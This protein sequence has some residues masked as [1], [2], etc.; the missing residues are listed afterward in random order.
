[1]LRRII[2]TMAFIA[3]GASA[4]AQSPFEQIHGDVLRKLEASRMR[5]VAGPW[6]KLAPPPTANQLL[7]DVQHYT[8]S[9]AINPTTHAVEGTVQAT[10]KSL[11]SGLSTIDLDADPVLTIISARIAGGAAL[12]FTR[13]SGVVTINLPAPL[14]GADLVTIEVSYT[15]DPTMAAEPGLFFRLVGTTQ[16]IYSLSE[17]W[18]ARAWWP[19]KDQPDDKAAFD[20]YLAVPEGLQAVSNG[21]F[22]GSAL[23]T[24]WGAWYRSYHWREDY[25]MSA[26]LASV[27]AT[28]YTELR[29]NFVY[30]PGDTMP[31]T[32]YVYPSLVSKALTDLSITAP[33]LSFF[34]SLFGLYP[35]VN[36]KYGVALCSIGGG[37][38]HQTLTSYGA[39]LV[40]GTHYYDWVYVH[41][42]SHQWFGDMITCKDW[43]N[44]WLNEGFASYC[45]A[46]W[47]EHL[48]GP[49]KLKSYMEGKDLVT[50]SGPVLRSPTNPS[51]DYYFDIVVYDKGAWVLHML[52]HVM[53][54]STFFHAMRD[55]ASDPRLRFAAAGTGD[56]RAACEARYGSSLGWFFNEWL[57][58]NDRLSYM[59]SHTAYPIE[60]G[61]N[62]TIVIDQGQDSLYTMPVDLR[63]TTVEHVV[64]T[65]VW[66][67][68]RHHEFHFV[69]DGDDVVQSVA[70][71]PGHW[72]LATVNEFT[73]DASTTPSAAFLDQNVP[74][75]FNPRTSIRFGLDAASTVR[76]DI[77][78]ARGALVRRLVDGRLESGVHEVSWAGTN[79][80]GE[81]VASGVY[82]YRLSA[83]RRD[84][85]RKMILLR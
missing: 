69:F 43:V 85:T 45:E 4:W 34:S 26:Y 73:T 61:T 83:G 36:E 13:S 53:G 72:I 14:A 56:F 48:Q 27:T 82:F 60:G 6:I 10:V 52:R 71:D 65:T 47:F 18:S 15:G 58:R 84:F 11:T 8:L 17:P 63:I 31:I 22:V 42:L 62:L 30:A 19:C 28:V 9:I 75:P 70:F 64:D 78:D 20:L 76:L 21:V 24:H 41:E 50:W 46:L 33:A 16:L 66:V 32:H 39:S 40:T 81:P 57:T 54:D 5:R 77:Y 7:Y 74:N 37:M 55:Y 29:D 3:A 80:R 67:S 44:V 12:T 38:E 2:I 68:E 23:E 59:W 35:F 79:G 1:M 49:A 25:P 51:Q